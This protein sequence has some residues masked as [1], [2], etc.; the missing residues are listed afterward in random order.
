M[1][2]TPGSCESN[3]SRMIMPSD[4]SAVARTELYQCRT[5]GLCFPGCLGPGRL[6]VSD[7]ILSVWEQTPLFKARCESYVVLLWPLSGRTGMLRRRPLQL[8]PS[9]SAYPDPSLPTGQSLSTLTSC[10]L[11]LGTAPARS[12]PPLPSP[13]LLHRDRLRH[14]HKRRFP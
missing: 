8:E 4:H 7:P 2:D 13:A 1:L 10:C 12:P 5:S 11:L 14:S 3:A 6:A 9:F